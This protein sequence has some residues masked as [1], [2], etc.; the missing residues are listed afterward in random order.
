MKK[1]IKK[2]ENFTCDKCHKTV[3]GNGYTNHCPHCLT[4]KHVDINPGDRLSA[5]H[6]LMMPIGIVKQKDNYLINFRCVK[7]NHTRS[8]RSAPND[9]FEKLIEI[10]QKSNS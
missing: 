10:S 4:S 3:I 9:N 1:F 6:G 8:N 7:C 5:C 2:I